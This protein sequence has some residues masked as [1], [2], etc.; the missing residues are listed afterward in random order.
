MDRHGGRI[1]TCHSSLPAGE[2]LRN[3][4][5][6][7][8]R[9]STC[10]GGGQS[11]RAFIYGQDVADAT[12]RIATQGMPGE[13]YHIST[14]EVIAVREL[15]ERICA[16]LGVPF[17]ASVEIVEERLGKD[18]A[19]MLDSTKLRQTLGWRDRISLDRG[20]DECITWIQ[21]HFDE[22]RHQEFD[23]VHKP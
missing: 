14:T 19:Y 21:R 8:C 23:Y 16:K 1:A 22:L 4:L 15:V 6:A 12:W 17:D 5:T 20:L 13:T 9:R 2:F 18:A 7:W 3:L 10:N 11:C